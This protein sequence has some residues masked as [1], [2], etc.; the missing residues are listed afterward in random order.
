MSSFNEGQTSR[1]TSC[2][3]VSR[4]WS[5]LLPMSRH[6]FPGFECPSIL[7]LHSIRGL[8]CNT[9]GGDT[10]P[11]PQYPEVLCLMD[12][13]T[14]MPFEN[15]Q[16]VRQASFVGTRWEISLTMKVAFEESNSFRFRWRRRW[17]QHPVHRDTLTHF[18][19]IERYKTAEIE[20]RDHQRIFV[21]LLEIVW[22]KKFLFPFST[23]FR[24][25]GS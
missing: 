5:S 20:G 1:R 9:F 16:P 24:S 17:A 8:L 15:D 11:P 14:F 22:K 10:P 23:H 3:M 4:G 25:W 7:P 19:Y 18:L 6:L 21:G 12:W 13:G 2:C